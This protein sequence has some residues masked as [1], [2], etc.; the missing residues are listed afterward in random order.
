MHSEKNKSEQYLRNAVGQ[1]NAALKMV[2]EDRYCVDIS[3]QVLAAI[4]LLKKANQEILR[5]H[6][7]HCVKESFETNS[8]EKIEEVLMLVNKITG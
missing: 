7:Y 8:D 5:N 3:H 1:V 4:A 2:E 6:M